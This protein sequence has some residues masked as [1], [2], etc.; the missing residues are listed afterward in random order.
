MKRTK[1][2][3][4]DCCYDVTKQLVKKSEFLWYAQQYMKDAKKNKHKKCEQVWKK[5]IADEKKHV[6][7]LKELCKKGVC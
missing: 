3:M 7:M 5:I 4:C 6:K 1:T 2:G